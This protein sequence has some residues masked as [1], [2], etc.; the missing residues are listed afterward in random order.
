MSHELASAPV[1][2]SGPPVATE[3]RALASRESEFPTRELT[4]VG[5]A[6]IAGIALG[7]LLKR[8]GR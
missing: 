3:R 6:V 5:L 2:L 4:I 8:G 7:Y 1:Q